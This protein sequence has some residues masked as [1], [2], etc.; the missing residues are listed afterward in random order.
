MET[1]FTL[2]TIS[3]KQ[4]FCF[5]ESVGYNVRRADHSVTR[6]A[7]T[8]NDYNI[9]FVT[10][11]KGY[12]E[13]D[14]IAHTLQKGDAVLYFPLQAQRY[15]SDLGDPWDVRFVHFYGHLLKDFLIEKGLHRSQLWTMRQWKPLEQAFEALTAEM[16]ENKFLYP[17][18]LSMLTYGILTEFINQAVPLTPNKG[19]DNIDR[20]IQ[21]LPDMQNSACLPFYLDEWADR[22]KVST[23]YF[24]KLFRQATQMTPLTFITLCRIRHA[25]QM[26]LEH[27]EATIQQIARES[28]YPSV[29]YFNKRFMEQ[30]GMTPSEYRNQYF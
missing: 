17:S 16:N 21:L 28:G 9:H 20:I 18:R 6:E 7:G 29:S 2:P 11:G 30:E 10:N 23:Y 15:Y 4:F 12:V 19:S 22:A 3:D 1:H 24:C 13:I 25:K 26:L 14:G 8:R 27:K 5:P